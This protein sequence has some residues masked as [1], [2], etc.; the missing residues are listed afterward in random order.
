MKNT[1]KHFY[2]NTK[3]TAYIIRVIYTEN[4]YWSPIFPDK[5]VESIEKIESNSFI[6][7]DIIIKCKREILEEAIKDKTSLV[8]K[9]DGFKLEQSYVVTFVCSKGKTAG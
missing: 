4:Q 7:V 5:E 1:K 3:P 9:K 2:I 6:K 8:W